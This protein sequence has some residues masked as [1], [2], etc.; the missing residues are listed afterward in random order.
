MDDHQVGETHAR[1]A[2]GIEEIQSFLALVPELMEENEAIKQQLA[3][4]NQMVE[5]L[6]REILE[7]RTENEELSRERTDMA[8]TIGRT[9]SDMLDLS[10]ELI[11]RLRAGDSKHRSDRRQAGALGDGSHGSR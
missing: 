4:T 2:R 1:I 8:E 9:M 6:R 5:T 11:Q 3:L 7:V 10:N